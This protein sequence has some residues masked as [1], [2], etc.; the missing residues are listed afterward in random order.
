MLRAG[1]V[2]AVRTLLEVAEDNMAARSLYAAE[3]FALVKRRP[4]YYR[5]PGGAA[6]AALVFAR[7]LP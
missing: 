3:G 1:R 6:A 4:R 7:D 5:R 2:G